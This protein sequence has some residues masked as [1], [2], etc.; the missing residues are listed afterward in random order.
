MRMRWMTRG[1]ITIIVSI[2][3]IIITIIDPGTHPRVSLLE[4]LGIE[5]LVLLLGIGCCY[6]AR[7][8]DKW[9]K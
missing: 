2:V 9:E 3:M 4:A 7:N 1:I 6:Y 8:K 5:F